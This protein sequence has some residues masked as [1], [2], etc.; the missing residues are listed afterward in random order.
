MPA[1]LRIY[2]DNTHTTEAQKATAASSTIS[3]T[4]A[5]GVTQLTLVNG[6]SFPATG[7]YLDI[8][9][10]TN[11]NESI[12]FIS[13]SG[14][15]VQLAKATQ[16]SHT[17]STV[18]YWRYSLPIGDQTNG[19]SND[20]SN[21]TP[22]VNNTATFYLYN[23]GDQ[24]AQSPSLAINSAAPSTASGFAD[25]RLSITSASSGFATS[26]SPANINVGSQVQFW[27]VA[28]IPSGQSNINNPQQCL[29]DLSYQSI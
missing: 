9:D 19:I 4:A 6:A 18:N 23:A 29:I 26:V 25:T 22:N 3:G 7:G 10:G 15:V 5:V 28:Q 17:N 16:F 13:V 20:G 14:N 2:S 12:P 21:V 1:F 8:I 24:T 11:G 27:I